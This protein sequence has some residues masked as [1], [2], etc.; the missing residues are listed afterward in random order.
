[1]L[2]RDFDI[3]L[4]VVT[5][6]GA[7]P[8]RNLTEMSRK[9]RRMIEKKRALAMEEV[10]S[11]VQGYQPDRVILFGSLA[12]GDA[13]E[14]SDVDLLVIKSDATGRLSDRIGEVLQFCSGRIDVEPLVYTPGELE[15][16][17]NAGN[18]LVQQALK[19]GEVVYDREQPP[20][21]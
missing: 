21:S 12:R 8:E 7:L 10:A 11:I 1:L 18:P 17:V 15:R 14:G 6:D 5:T 16:M 13:C 3:K 20:Q 4:I 2:E 9:F 19:E